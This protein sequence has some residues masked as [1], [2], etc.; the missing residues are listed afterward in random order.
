LKKSE[1]EEKREEEL[2]YAKYLINLAKKRDEKVNKSLS[3]F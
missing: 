2:L 1:E 3:K